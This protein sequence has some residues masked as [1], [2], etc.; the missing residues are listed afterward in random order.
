MAKMLQI[1]PMK[2]LKL[3]G[4][5]IVSTAILLSLVFITVEADATQ[6]ASFTAKPGNGQILIEWETVTELDL[7]GF[8]L[9]RSLQFDG[10]YERI[11]PFFPAEG[12]IIIGYNYSYLDTE[13]VN[14]TEYFYM[15][16]VVKIDNS[17][18]E[19]GPIS[20]IPGAPTVTP[21]STQSALVY[22]PLVEYLRIP[23]QTPIVTI[24][25]TPDPLEYFYSVELENGILLIWSPNEGSQ[26]LG[27]YVKRKGPSDDYFINLSD[28][29]PADGCTH[30]S[31]CYDFLDLSIPESGTYYYLLDV[32]DSEY[33]I[34]TYGPTI[35]T[36]DLGTPTPTY[37][38]DPHMTYTP[39]SSLTPTRTQTPSMTPKP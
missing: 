15:L 25:P 5:F 35:I 9:N 16:E 20:V 18:E 36:F 13:V 30:S 27:F 4:L 10:P 33:N 14:G 39:T 31:W 29:I 7:A 24:S 11:G 6:L 17:V 3:I 21:T 23:I 19:H 32:I 26:L 2:L 22:L 12:D 8:F 1:V 37:T 38:E 28:F 34:T